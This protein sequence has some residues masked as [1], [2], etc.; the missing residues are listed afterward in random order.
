MGGAVSIESVRKAYCDVVAPDRVSLALRPV[1]FL[2]LF[3]PEAAAQV[4]DRLLWLFRRPLRAA[5]EA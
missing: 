3:E 2:T 4:R 1:E 5:S